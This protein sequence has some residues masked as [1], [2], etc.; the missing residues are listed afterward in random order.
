MMDGGLI[1]GTITLDQ[2]GLALLLPMHVVADRHGVI[3]A[4]GPTARKL[5]PGREIIGENLFSVI[6]FRRPCGIRTI[7]DL[8][9]AQGQKLHLRARDGHDIPLKGIAV[10]LPG[11]GCLLSLSFGIAIVDAVARLDLNASDF[12]PTDLAVEMLFLVE[13]KSAAMAASRELNEKLQKARMAAEE[14][15]YTDTLTGLCNRRA[16]DR[17][18]SRLVESGEKF[19]LMHLDLDFFKAVNDTHGH[20]AGDHV[21]QQVARILKEE[22]REEDLVARV[23]GDE[24]ILLIS[25]ITD[26]ERLDGIARR[27][28]AGLEQPIPYGDVICRISGS[29]GTTISDYYEIP[30]IDRMMQDADSALYASKHKGRACHTI[31]IPQPQPRNGAAGSAE[32]DR[33]GELPRR[34]DRADQ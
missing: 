29:I 27:I 10:P 8:L 7:A 22:T 4:C 28:I 12:A 34:A 32:A 13:A 31:F 26:H 33:Q 17:M 5:C 21:L 30:E 3:T 2:E 1:N 23:G 25:R 18:L 14:Q 15:A 9:H 20:A 24:F 6:D 11:Q 16:A 19:S